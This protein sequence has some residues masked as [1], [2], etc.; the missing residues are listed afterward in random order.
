MFKSLMSLFLVSMA[1]LF[2]AVA[3]AKQQQMPSQQEQVMQG[4]GPGPTG[5]PPVRDDHLDD[6]SPFAR[7]QLQRGE[8]ILSTLVFD[9]QS[10]HLVLSDRTVFGGEAVPP[11]VFSNKPTIILYQGALS[12][13]RSNEEIAFMMAH[14]LGHLNLHHMEK[15]N[16]QMDKIFTGHPIRASGTTFAIYKQKLQ[17]QEADMFGLFLYNKAGYDLAF[18]PKTLKI[19]KMNPNIHFGT[20]NIVQHE[21]PSSL[22]MKDSHFKMSERFELLVKEAQKIA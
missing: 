12:P 5:G 14:E 21:E 3:M 16:V 1:F 9:P 7:Q 2:P 4:P 17:E 15:M 20:N 19:L 8:Q 18:F 6:K 10:Y 13:N 11:H 22:S